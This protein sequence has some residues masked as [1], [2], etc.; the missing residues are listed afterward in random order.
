MLSRKRLFKAMLHSTL[1]KPSTL[2][3]PAQLDPYANFV[4]RSNP[5][6]KIRSCG[7]WPDKGVCSILIRRVS[8]ATEL[9][10]V[11]QGGGGT[12]VI[13]FY[14]RVIPVQYG[15]LIRHREEQ[16]GHVSNRSSD[17]GFAPH[18][19]TCH[20]ILLV[21]EP[22][23]PEMVCTLRNFELRLGF[24]SSYCTQRYRSPG[25]D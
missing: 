25:Y 6:C 16:E 15:S 18:Q 4:G 7:R 2:A 3:N 12:T 10:L 21:Y 19:R 1:T 5:L 24:L 23:G 22:V 13:L 8:Q 14:A 17:H 20:T 11:K 9:R